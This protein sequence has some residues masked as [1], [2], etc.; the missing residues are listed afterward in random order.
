MPIL[1]YTTTYALIEHLERRDA[2]MIL[3]E[4]AI[5]QSPATFFID[6]GD[7]YSIL[8]LLSG[9]SV[10]E[11]VPY[12]EELAPRR[13]GAWKGK[14]WMASDFDDDQEI[15]ELFEGSEKSFDGDD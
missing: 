5:S 12:K 8:E 6:A 7:L 11:K 10:I 13:F 2:R 1:P 4:V 15:I 14:V 9:K 3:D